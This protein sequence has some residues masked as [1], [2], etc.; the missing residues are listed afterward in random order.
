MT[1]FEEADHS[2]YYKYFSKGVRN[3]TMN[4][5]TVCP[6]AYTNE[7]EYIENCVNQAVFIDTPTVLGAIYLENCIESLDCHF[8][9]SAT[10][11]TEFYASGQ[12]PEA[13]F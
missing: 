2:P 3:I 11:I 13:L 5:N 9:A 1:V 6:F 7:F 8:P 12:D 4:I 10:Y